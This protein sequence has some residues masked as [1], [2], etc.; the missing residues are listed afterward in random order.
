MIHNTSENYQPTPQRY[1]AIDPRV[2]PERCPRCGDTLKLYHTTRGNRP[3]HFLGCLS[4]PACSYTANYDEPL[5]LFL[6]R[7]GER[8]IRAE[9]H[10]A[11]LT[12]QV[13]E[14]FARQEERGQA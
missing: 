5:L 9:A 7:L 1:H 11:W 12:V 10:I 8:L 2:L 3:R 4:Y 13:E 14:L 6:Q